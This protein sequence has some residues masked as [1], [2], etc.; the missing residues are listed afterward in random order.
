MR[1]RALA[2]TA[3]GVFLIDTAGV[4][5]LAIDGLLADD[6]LGRSIALGVATLLAVPLA[7]LLAGLAAST[8]WRSR[9]GLWICLALAVVPIILA[10]SNIIRHSA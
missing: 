5:W 4:A 2:I 7:L 3:W 10:L 1:L 6:A 8:W 9:V